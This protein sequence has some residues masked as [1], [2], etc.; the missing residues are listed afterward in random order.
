MRERIVGLIVWLVVT[1]AAAFVGSQ[2]LPGEWYASLAKPTWTPPNG[3]FAPVWTV[4]Y[5]M[6]AV[7]AWM[8][9][10]ERGVGG[11]AVPLGLF[12]AQ[13]VLNA[14]WSWLFFGLHRPDWSLIE[15]LILWVAILATLITFWRI[16][17]AAG[18]LL[19]PYLLWVT[20]A[21]ALNFELWRL[22]A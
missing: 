5:A 17:I 18:A 22:N 11:A 9:W 6:M 10:S 15:I 13:L 21:T 12:L 16:R 8:I 14:V 7:A 19:I 1:F 4:L 20:F 3:V 2:F